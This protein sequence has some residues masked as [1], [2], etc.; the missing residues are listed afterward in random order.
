MAK[1]ISSKV[2]FL[3]A[4]QNY[5]FGANFM[6]ALSAG[7]A[8]TFLTQPT[9]VF[10]CHLQIDHKEGLSNFRAHLIERGTLRALF[11]GI[12]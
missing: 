11:L 1:I 6:C 10:R 5:G 3:G 7:A 4:N 2:Q 12:F 8:A 9:D